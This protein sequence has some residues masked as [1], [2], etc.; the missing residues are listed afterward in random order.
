MDIKIER[1]EDRGLRNQ[2]RRETIYVN[3]EVTENY[4]RSSMGTSGSEPGVTMAID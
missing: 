3:D 2:E 4:D 1:E